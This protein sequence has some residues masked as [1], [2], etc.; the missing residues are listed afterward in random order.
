MS[1]DDAIPRLWMLCEGGH[2]MVL[3][4]DEDGTDYL[5]CSEYPTCRR[6]RKLPAYLHL[7]RSGAAEL[8]GMSEE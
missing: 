8:P 7:K 1:D 6:R 2:P 3:R 5:S 4:A